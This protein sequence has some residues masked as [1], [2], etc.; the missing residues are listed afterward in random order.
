[1]SMCGH[2]VRKPLFR[3]LLKVD[4]G[5]EKRAAWRKCNLYL[6]ER[7]IVLNI[8]F[9]KFAS[10]LST[11]TVAFEHYSFDV[12]LLLAVITILLLWCNV[13]IFTLNITVQLWSHNC[14]TD[15]NA[16]DLSFGKTCTI[17]D[18][19]SNSFIPE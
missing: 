12:G 18:L 1:M 6:L 16:L 3:A 11:V 19:S 8:K 9:L 4:I 10:S 15:I 14:G 13:A 17:L 5:G 7:V 2:V